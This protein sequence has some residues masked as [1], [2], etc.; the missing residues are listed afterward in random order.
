MRT[1]NENECSSFFIEDGYGREIKEFDKLEDALDFV[2][3]DSYKAETLGLAGTELEVYG[4][5]EKEIIDE[6]DLPETVYE[7][8]IISL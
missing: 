3:E 8:V 4:Y 1:V 2:N 5:V 6:F 7:K